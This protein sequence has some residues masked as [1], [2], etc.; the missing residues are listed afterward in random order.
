MVT[1]PEEASLTRAMLRRGARRILSADHTKVDGRSGTSPTARS[2][3]SIS[4]SRPR[5]SSPG[6]SRFLSHARQHQGGNDMSYDIGWAKVDL[7]KVPHLVTAEI[8]GPKS[9]EHARP[10]HEDHEG[11]VRPGE[12]VPRGLRERARLHADRRGRQHVPRLLVGHLRDHPRPLPPQGDR[13]GGEVRE[14]ADERA[15]LHHPDQG[16]AAGEDDRDPPEG[17][18]RRAALRQRHHGSGG[19]PPRLPGRH[20]EARVPLLLRGFPRQERAL[21]QPRAHELHQRRR[22]G[23]RAS[24]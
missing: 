6:N 17:P 15:R 1:T 7:K 9:R 10:G 2:P 22:H 13:G 21:G 3:T 18:L 23:R 20:R 8:P 5:A 16:E 11:A 19:G 14:A 24:T 4:G 12:A